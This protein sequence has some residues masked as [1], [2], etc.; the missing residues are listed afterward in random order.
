MTRFDA[1]RWSLIAVASGETAESRVALD[2]LCR[3]Y[4]PAVLA[5][6]R[7]HGYPKPDA[8]D[9]TQDFFA[10]FLEKRL[11]ATADRQRGRFRVWLRKVLQ[12]FLANA[13]DFAQAQRRAPGTQL[14]GDELEHIPADGE[15]RPDRV[16][17]RAWALV[18][19]RH[20][21]TRLAEEHARA[22]KQ[23]LFDRLSGFLLDHPESTDY[24]RL[25][26]E[27]GIRRNTLAVTLHRLRQR[28]DQLIVEV[29]ADTVSQESEL[30]AEFAVL[31]PHL[32]ARGVRRPAAASPEP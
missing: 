22:G 30:D 16:F 29:V 17:E 25:C 3:L 9:L 26:A 20:A 10:R 13:K 28:L 8:E 5:F 31:E 27:L 32:G 18:I 7:A 11:Y 15:A 21:T 12:H 6:I 24:D 19:L 23:E 1:T 2:E 14:G 4:R